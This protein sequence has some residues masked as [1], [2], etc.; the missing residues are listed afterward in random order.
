MFTVLMDCPAIEPISGFAV[1]TRKAPRPLLEF[2][3][4]NCCSNVPAR[5]L[6]LRSA[7]TTTPVVVPTYTLPLAII[8]VMNLL[9]IN[10]S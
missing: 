3:A 2:R 8:G 7:N 9:P 5:S 6:Q 4:V 10:W 1:I